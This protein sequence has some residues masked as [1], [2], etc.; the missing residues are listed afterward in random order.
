MPATA[1]SARA[2]AQVNHD[3]QDGAGRS[4]SNAPIHP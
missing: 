3:L 4:V 2:G 1:R